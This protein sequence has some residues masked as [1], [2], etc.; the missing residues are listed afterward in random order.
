MQYTSGPSLPILRRR[1]GYAANIGLL[2]PAFL[3]AACQDAT[4]PLAGLMTASVRDSSATG[5]VETAYEG[6]GDFGVGTDPGAGVSITFGLR[7]KGN[8]TS[9]GQSFALTRPGQDRPAPGRYDLAPLDLSNGQMNGFTAHY[10]R[11]VPGRSEDFTAVS[12]YLVVHE[13]TEDRVAGE[14]QVTMVQYC[15]ANDVPGADDWC[16]APTTITPGAPRIIVAGSF[17]AVPVKGGQ[18]SPTLP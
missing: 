8:G 18:D 11:H 9:A 3:L 7:S 10:Y 16:A 17:T 5:V 1:V 14:F 12:G 6:S 15:L 4:Q 2:V 13:S